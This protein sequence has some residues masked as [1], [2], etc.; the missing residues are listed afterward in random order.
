MACRLDLFS[1]AI[2]LAL[3]LFALGSIRSGRL[4]TI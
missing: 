1:N 2:A 3:R 4:P